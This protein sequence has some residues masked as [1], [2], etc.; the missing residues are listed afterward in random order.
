MIKDIGL[1]LQCIR[2]KKGLTVK[3]FAKVLGVSAGYISQL[4]NGKAKTISFDLLD[5]LQTKYNILPLQ[6]IGEEDYIRRL[7]L[8]QQLVHSNPEAAEY[9]LSTF[10]SG[11][12]FF[13]Q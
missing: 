4:E 10:E 6:T 5:L 13:L 7:S 11:L 1:R 12:E 9:I 8:L 2:N 3:E